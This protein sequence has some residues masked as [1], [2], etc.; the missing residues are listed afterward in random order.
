MFITCN[1]SAMLK[2]AASVAAGFIA[3]GEIDKFLEE[4]RNQ[5]RMI[6]ED[7]IC[8]HPEDFPLVSK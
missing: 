6:I 3:G 4:R 1:I 5:N 2:H 8:R 7:Y